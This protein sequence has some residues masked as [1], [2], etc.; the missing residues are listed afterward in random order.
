MGWLVPND[1]PTG[2]K[3]DIRAQIDVSH[4]VTVKV[5]LECAGETST[6]DCQGPFCSFHNFIIYVIFF[7]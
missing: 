4:C 1:L 3:A 5:G 6:V 2:K 7:T